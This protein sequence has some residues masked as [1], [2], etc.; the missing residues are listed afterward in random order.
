MGQGRLIGPHSFNPISHGPLRCTYSMG[1]GGVII[2]LSYILPKNPNFLT[3]FLTFGVT[4][5]SYMLGGTSLK[6]DRDIESK[7]KNG[8]HFNFWFERRRLIR[9]IF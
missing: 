7:I 2:I 8:S 6:R 9:T 4:P 1:G 5:L 3:D